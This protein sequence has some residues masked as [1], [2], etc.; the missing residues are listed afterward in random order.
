MW[1]DIGVSY[2]HNSQL[3]RIELVCMLSTEYC[4]SDF[5]IH[6]HAHVISLSTLKVFK[7]LFFELIIYKVGTNCLHSP[8][9]ISTGSHISLSKGPLAS[10]KEVGLLQ[11]KVL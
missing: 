4:I 8:M 10:I 3:I 6:I 9:N 5:T 2:N 7:F 11:E 1:I